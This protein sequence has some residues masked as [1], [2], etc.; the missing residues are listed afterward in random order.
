VKIQFI[1]RTRYGESATYV[2]ADICDEHEPATCGKLAT[3]EGKAATGRTTKSIEPT[4]EPTAEPAAELAAETS[5]DLPTRT[6]PTTETAIRRE[7]GLGQRPPCQANAP[8]QSIETQDSG[9]RC[10][11]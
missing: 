11:S 9:L 2:K 7:Q 6:G 5:T 3:C 1:A 8:L 10:P 4:A